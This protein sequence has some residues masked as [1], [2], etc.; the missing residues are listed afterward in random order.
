MSKP[1]GKIESSLDERN[2]ADFFESLFFRCFSEANWFRQPVNVP[3]AS[4]THGGEDVAIYATGPMSHLFRGVVEQNYVAHAMA[5][6]SCVGSNK[7]HCASAVSDK[8][9][10]CN[11][12][13]G[14]IKTSVSSRWENQLAVVI[15]ATCSVLL[16]AVGR[17]SYW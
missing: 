9:T 6:A 7:A 3:L 13:K 14:I 11:S 16:S 2:S 8:P 15:V 1:I 10:A 4:E 17:Y 5:Y 12:G